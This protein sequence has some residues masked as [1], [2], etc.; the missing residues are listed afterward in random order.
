[1]ASA[2]SD[3]GDTEA[4]EI[5]Y[6][7]GQIPLV[8]ASME[9]YCGEKGFAGQSLLGLQHLWRIGRAMKVGWW[10]VGVAYL[11]SACEALETQKRVQTVH[12]AWKAVHR[13]HW[14]RGKP[15]SSGEQDEDDGDD[16]DGDIW[17]RTHNG[18]SAYATGARWDDETKRAMVPDR[19]AV[20]SGTFVPP[21]YAVQVEQLPRNVDVEWHSFGLAKGQVRLLAPNLTH[22]RGTSTFFFTLGIEERSDG[23]DTELLDRVRAQLMQLVNIARNGKEV[24]VAYEHVTLYAT[25]TLGKTWAGFVDGLQWIPVKSVWGVEGDSMDGVPYEHAS[26]VALGGVFIGRISLALKE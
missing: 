10:T 6:T 8:P 23:G 7:A 17:D 18:Y 11:S 12:E 14:L 3:Q 9:V 2:G 16:G 15:G 13:E 4:P 21:C 5:V 22:V 24:H 1:M 25:P 20:H 26:S 19:R